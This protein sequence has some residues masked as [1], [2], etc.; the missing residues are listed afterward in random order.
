MDPLLRQLI[1]RIEA[2][3][4]IPFAAYMDVA[5]YDSQHGYY[6]LGETRTGRRGD[7]MTSP[8]LDPAFAALWLQGLEAIWS[9]CGRPD[10]FCVVE[11]GPGEGTFASALLDCAEGD[12]AAALR[13][14]LVDP[15]P[16]P[17]SR[18]NDLLR[19][20]GVRWCSRPAELEPLGAG[21]VFANEVLD[22]QPVHV[23]RR[24]SEAIEELHVDARNG[25]LV[26]T[27]L[28][29]SDESLLN[30]AGDLPAGARREISPAAE[31]L[32]TESLRVV[33]R[34]ACVFVD[35]GYRQGFADS[36]VAYSSRGVDVPRLD[37]PGREDI[38]AHVDWQAVARAARAG[39]AVPCRVSSQR[40][41]LRALGAAAQ[42]DALKKEHGEALGAGNGARAVRALSRRQSLRALLDPSGLGGLD[43]F[44]ALKGI[45]EPWFLNDAARLGEADEKEKDRPEGRPS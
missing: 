5:L 13:V 31:A 4:P 11:L 39:G 30:R 6:A 33:R 27:W 10:D 24:R 3:G 7:Y 42:D 28:L 36:L 32:V 38:T 20:D 40:D 17:P 43:V 41:V 37:R 34:G 18:R 9:A 29:C 12:L 8:E 44:V 35:Y 21:C 26:E 45:D 2:E 22:N 23:L 16:E 19:R 25:A 15:A 1:A 14:T